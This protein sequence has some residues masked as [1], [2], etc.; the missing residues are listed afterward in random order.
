MD[1]A[2]HARSHFRVVG[3]RR[4]H[5]QSR[6]RAAAPPGG[7]RSLLPGQHMANAAGDT[8][9]QIRTQEIRLSVGSALSLTSLNVLF[10]RRQCF[11]L[12]CCFGKHVSG[13]T[14]CS[15]FLDRAFLFGALEAR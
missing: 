15:A 6:A 9:D 8:T 12:V 7:S 2:A 10:G 5:A 14:A 13:R 4:R 3:V 11:P 1:P